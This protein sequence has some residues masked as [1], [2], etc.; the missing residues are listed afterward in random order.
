[1][2]LHILFVKLRNKTEKFKYTEFEKQLLQ[3][4]LLFEQGKQLGVRLFNEKNTNVVYFL[5][6]QLLITQ[7]EIEDKENPFLEELAEQIIEEFEKSTLL[8]LKNKNQLFTFS[9]KQCII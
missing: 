1:M 2:I 8:P 4:Q 5:T 7:Q 9:K 3:R 6:I